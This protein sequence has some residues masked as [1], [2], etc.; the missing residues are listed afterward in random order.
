MSSAAPER[1]RFELFVYHGKDLP[2]DHLYVKSEWFAQGEFGSARPGELVRLARVVYP[3]R[4]HY[5]TTESYIVRLMSHFD[6][7]SITPGVRHAHCGSRF[8]AS[9]S[10]ELR[11]ALAEEDSSVEVVLEPLGPWPN[12]WDRWRRFARSILRR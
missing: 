1:G 11:K 10:P 3:P 2:P 9:R 4:G 5:Y 6:E 7:D 12:R 8:L